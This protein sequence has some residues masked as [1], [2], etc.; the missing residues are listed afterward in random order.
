LAK[1]FPDLPRPD[2]LA[3]NGPAAWLNLQKTGHPMQRCVQVEALRYLYLNELFHNSEK[4]GV[5]SQ[6]D[7][8][9][10]L[11]LGDIK[12]ETTH[13]MILLLEHVYEKIDINYEIWIKPHPHNQIELGKYPKL[14]AKCTDLTLLELFQLTHVALASVFTSAALDAFCCGIPV[15]NYLDPDDIN[16]SNL[17]GIKSTRFVST[18]NALFQALEQ[19][20]SGEFKTGKPEDFFWLEPE[21][22]KW[23]ELFKGEIISQLENDQSGLN[24]AES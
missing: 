7:K 23:R 21:L 6:V 24:T 10:L 16:L 1:N 2:A 5:T 15:I 18:E 17:R 9:Y 8:R 12:K 22:P 4:K 13:R 11:I 3:V 19:I 20:E 14:E